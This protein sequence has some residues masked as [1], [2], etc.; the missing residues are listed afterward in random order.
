[1]RIIEPKLVMC[2]YCKGTGKLELTMPHPPKLL[3]IRALNDRKLLKRILPH[4]EVCFHCK[5]TGRC[6]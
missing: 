3:L 1:M 2:P 6:E 4:T 5:G